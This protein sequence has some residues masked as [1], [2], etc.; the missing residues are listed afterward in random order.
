VQCLADGVWDVAAGAGTLNSGVELL[1]ER[2]ER[3]NK[4]G[5]HGV[6]LR[7][8]PN[9]PD[10]GPAVTA[11]GTRVVTAHVGRPHHPRQWVLTPPTSSRTPQSQALA[12]APQLLRPHSTPSGPPPVR[13]PAAR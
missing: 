7:D 13:P 8:G 3:G 1:D 10:E 11:L 9:G 12:R 5:G 6:L 2:G 4:S